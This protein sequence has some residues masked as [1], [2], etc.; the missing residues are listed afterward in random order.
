MPITHGVSMTNHNNEQLNLFNQPTEVF[1][2]VGCTV[3]RAAELVGRSKACIYRH[4][5][6]D[7]KPYRREVDTGAWVV[8]LNSKKNGSILVNVGFVFAPSEKYWRLA[9]LT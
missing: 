5:S 7:S 1:I 9:Q 4:L 8:Y 2:E 6:Q 3:E